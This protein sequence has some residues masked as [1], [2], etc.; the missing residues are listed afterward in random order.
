MLPVLNVAAYRF[1]D[2]DDL[3]SLRGRLYEAAGSRALKGTI[4]LAPEGLNLFLAGSPPQVHEF[5][6]D[7]QADARFAD[8]PVRESW[9]ERL[10]FRRL[11]VRLK[12]EII[13]MDTPS[14]RPVSGRAPGID[15]QT[16]N[17][18]LDQGHDDDG[19]P[20]LMLDT[21]NAFEVDAGRFAGALDWRLDR[22]GRFPEALRQHRDALAGHTVVS[23]CT[24]GIRCEKAAL[25]MREAGVEHV[26][27]LDGGILA[28]LAET[29]APHWRGDCIVFD[30]RGALNPSLSPRAPLPT[31]VRDSP[32]PTEPSARSAALRCEA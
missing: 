29:E 28:Y 2:L 21:R 8:L 20:L 7:L 17:R 10:P 14:I 12:R 18:W 24:G 3:A 25:L 19:R 6:H 23:Y 9:S 16:L 26:H 13:R 4:L 30:D 22:F 1:V 5:L 31:P 32:T 15:P 27:Q 11:R